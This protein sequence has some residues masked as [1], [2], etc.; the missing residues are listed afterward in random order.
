MDRVAALQRGRNLEWLTIGWNSL[1]AVIA[2]V[3]GLM[4]GSI[5]L[6]SFG[7]DSV[8]ELFASSVLLW[9]L[10]TYNNAA[11]SARIETTALRLVGVS[12]LM[13]AIY[14]CADSAYA[15]WMREIPKQSLIGIII[16]AAS[17]MVMP[18]LARA[19]RNVACAI[20]SDA[21]HA[22]SRQT[23]LCAYLS[24]I[25]LAGLALNAVL[26]W[27][28][29]DPVAALIMVPIIVHEAREAL[30]GKKCDCEHC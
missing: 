13:L 2:L 22:E 18:L 8:I 28:W 25:T 26:G 30:A 20:S 10:R 14:I 27:W 5:A 4:A 24:V 3:A 7:L 6:T 16:T 17:V 1:E 12:F 29:A 19:K 11:K 23:D 15:L 21:L 9:R